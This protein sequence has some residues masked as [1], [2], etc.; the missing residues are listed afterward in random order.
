MASPPK[1]VILTRNAQPIDEGDRANPA[2]AVLWGL[3]RTLA[4]EHPEIWGSIIDVDDSVPPELI[5]RYVRAEV[6]AADGEDQVAYQAGVRHVPRLERRT[7]PVSLTRLEG[8]PVTWLSGLPA[9]SGQISSDNSRRW[10]PRR[11]SRCPDTRARDSRSWLSSLASRGTKLIEV[12]ADAA[13]E[14]AMTALF[15]RFGTDL[16]PL[17]GIYLAAL[18]GGAV[19][20]TDMTDDDVNTMFRPKL[21]AV[22]VLHRLSL[23]TPVRQFV[24]FSSITGVLGSRWLAHYTATGAFLDTF[25]Y[26]RRA[27]GLAATVVD[28]GLWKSW[29][30]A[31]PAT[32]A[33]GLQ[34]MP[35]ELAIRTLPA[36]MSPEAGVR[37]AVVAADWRLLAEAYRMRGSLRV[38]DHLLPDDSVD[39]THIDHVP[40]PSYGTVLGE[41]VAVATTPPARFVAGAAGAGR[42]SRIRAGIGSTAWRWF[43]YRFCCRHFRRRQPNVADRCWVTFD[44]S[45]RSS[46]TS[47]G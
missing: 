8:D 41:H 10:G 32:A 44:S 42:P 26:A 20:L 34:P 30:D 28:W 13:D 16:P 2:H 5:S 4:L 12:A 1:L 37:S 6:H 15:E 17:D 45:I 38:V 29:A 9:T 33:S 24:L 18:A 43:R 19:Q 3:G 11:S 40:E 46:S 7:P 35:N 27:L 39:P 21:D 14:T 31:P 22:S 36:V 23:K 25:A 47:R